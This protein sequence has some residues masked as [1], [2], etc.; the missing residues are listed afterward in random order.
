LENEK[1]TE[2]LKE[3]E[4]VLW[5]GK[6]APFKTFG[7]DFRM[8]VLQTFLLYA[9]VSGV[10]IVL[11]HFFGGADD[12][13]TMRL[14]YIA[15]AGIPA[16][17]M[18]FSLFTYRSFRKK[19]TYCVT[20]QSIIGYIFRR[21]NNAL[22]SERRRQTQLHFTERRYAL[23]PGRLRLG[24]QKNRTRDYAIRPFYLEPEEGRSDIRYCVLYNLPESDANKVLDLIRANSAVA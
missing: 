2:M 18:V 4:V 21:G 23:H 1:I 10:L 13:R 11:Y 3:D 22:P 8:T 19:C 7:S 15:T 14:S 12:E 20:N 16:V 9:L 17:M 5:T 24:F 6:P